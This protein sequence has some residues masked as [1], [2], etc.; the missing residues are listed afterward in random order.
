MDLVLQFVHTN[1]QNPD[2][3]LLGTDTL[4]CTP[5][6]HTQKFIEACSRFR[7][8]AVLAYGSIME[9]WS[10]AGSFSTERSVIENRDRPARR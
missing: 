5:S 7:E 2:W 9:A 10:L 3:K 6:Q 1:F 8:A 4:K